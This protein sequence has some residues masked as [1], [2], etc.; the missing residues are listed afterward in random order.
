M[1]SEDA[2]TETEL[3]SDEPVADPYAGDSEAF[4]DGT[5]ASAAPGE[6]ETTSSAAEADVAQEASALSGSDDGVAA[7]DGVETGEDRPSDETDDAKASAPTELAETSP[8]TAPS[9]PAAS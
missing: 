7:A 2:E 4:S 6:E 9:E 8:E 3:S 1:A 5:S